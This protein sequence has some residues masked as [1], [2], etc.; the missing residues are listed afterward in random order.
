MGSWDFHFQFKKH[1][2]TG[3]LWF[4]IFTTLEQCKFENFIREFISTA[5][6]CI[7]VTCTTTLVIIIPAFLSSSI[8]K[9]IVSYLGFYWRFDAAYALEKTRRINLLSYKLVR[10]CRSSF[11]LFIWI[12]FINGLSNLLSISFPCS[13]VLHEGTWFRT[14][15]LTRGFMEQTVSFRALFVSSTLQ[16]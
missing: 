7:M 15:W 1:D 9:C 4:S 8:S 14:H 10:A 13:T 2:L 5:V 16:N 12:L 6:A 11:I 3:E